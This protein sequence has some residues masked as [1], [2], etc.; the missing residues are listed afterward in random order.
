MQ[1]LRLGDR[2]AAVA[3]V[4]TALADLGHLPTADGEPVFDLSVDHAVRAFQ[5]R[6]GL[7]VDGLVGTATYRALKEASYKLGAR[8]LIYQLSAP[9]SGDDVVGLQTRL[10]ELGYNSGRPDGIFG[11]Q[12]D[13]ALRSFQRECGITSDGIC[14]PATLRALG[15]LARMASGG[16]PQRIREEEAVRLSGPQLRG[17]RIVIDP[18]HGGDDLGVLASHYGVQGPGAEL[19]EAD[20]VWDLATLLEGRLAATGV[21]TF[22]S[23]PKHANPPDSERAAFANSCGADLLISLHTDAWSSPHAQ[24]VSS[25]YFG[26]AEGVSSTVGEMLGGFILREI[27]ARTGMQ[28][29]Q[30]HGRTWD[31]LRLT[32]MPAVHVELGYLSNDE[33]SA[34]L[35]HPRMR[36]AIAEAIVVAVKR[37]YMLGIDDQP[38]GTFTFAE[39]LAEEMTG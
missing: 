18:G 25:F 9:M 24:G 22:L 36:D 15:Y 10:L 34:V 8:T 17:K 6:R 38:T 32:K 11:A 3:E 21:E 27:V 12:T 7:I 16:S 39:L 31:L 35:A 2:G 20:V 14:G 28:S 13:Q 1:L 37:L 4:R 29:C 23:R 30:H 33:D 5:Q 26:N 19:N